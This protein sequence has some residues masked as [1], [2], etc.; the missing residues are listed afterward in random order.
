MKRNNIRNTVK[1]GVILAVVSGAMLPVAYADSANNSGHMHNSP[2]TGHMIGGSMM[3]SHHRE[4]MGTGR[5]NKVMADKH[6]I[7]I[8]HEPI[9]EM[10]WPK[11]RM[12]FK[13]MEQLNMSELEPGQEVTFTL[14]VDE[15]NNYVIKKIDAK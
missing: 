8:S 2:E 14:D 1:A 7:N 4:V 11:M 13:T 15:N 12:N 10:S 5:I 9:A 3:K 6:M